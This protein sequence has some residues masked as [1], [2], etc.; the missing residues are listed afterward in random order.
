MPGESGPPA[1][2]CL[3][4][5]QTYTS[6]S[7]FIRNEKLQRL[8]DH[9]NQPESDIVDCQLLVP[10][11][12]GAILLVPADHPFDDIPPP[13]RPPI[14]SLVARLIL[15]RRD[16][17]LDSPPAA[18]APDPRVTVTLVSRQSVRPTALA[19]AAIEEPMGH[20]RL[21][22][23][24]LVR[25]AGRDVD[26]HDEAAAVA[27]QVDLRPEPA[28]RTPQGMVW[29]LLHKRP[30]APTQPT[31]VARPFLPAPTA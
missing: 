30:L 27:D 20:R 14:E 23:L 8:L 10:R 18:P 26:R 29:R 5:G 12:E 21:E 22:R 15:P 31:R 19:S 9:G 28:A 13:V 4:I 17:R 3:K 25:L 24:T 1:R 2:L 7:G 11:P 16:D 6:R